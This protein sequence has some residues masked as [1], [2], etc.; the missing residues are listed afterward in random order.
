MSPEAAIEV[1]R[2][3]AAADASY[4]YGIPA[5]LVVC[6]AGILIL[7]VLLRAL[8][9]ALRDVAAAG[10]A[11]AG[12]MGLRGAQEHERDE[13]TARIE[14]QVNRLVDELLRRS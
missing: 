3:H 8:T 2:D 13:A 4:Q 5:L 9:A 7:A 6:V 1:H 10:R 14:A 12:I 11:V